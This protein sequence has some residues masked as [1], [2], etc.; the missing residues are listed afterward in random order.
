ML[1]G[2]HAGFHVVAIGQAEML[3]R[4]DVAEHGRAEPADH[5]RADA[6]GDV[7]VARCNV[8][9]QRPKRVEGRFVAVP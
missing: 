3:L 4:R 2:D 1:I 6:R 8:C 5:R 9:R 7:V